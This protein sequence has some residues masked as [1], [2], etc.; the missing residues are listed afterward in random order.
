MYHKGHSGM[1]DFNKL[2][3]HIRQGSDLP[4]NE[5]VMDQLSPKNYHKLKVMI[6]D[7][8][9]PVFVQ[10]T[11]DVMWDI[12]KHSVSKCFEFRQLSS[13]FDQGIE[14]WLEGTS[15]T[16]ADKQKFRDELLKDE[17]LRR[18][19]EFCKCFIKAETYPE[20]KYPRPIKSRTDKFKARMGPIFQGINDCLF[21][22]LKYFIKKIPVRDRPKWLYER[23]CRS[24]KIDC[25]DFSSFEAHFIN[26]MMFAI[27]FP[28]YAWATAKLY[29]HTWFMT[30][31]DILLQPNKCIFYDF[32]V[33]S[34]SRA[35]GEMNTSS[36]NGYSNMIL[37]TYVAR[38]KGAVET[39]QGFEGDDGIVTADPIDSLPLSRDYDDL[40]W[41]CKLVTAE[42]F[43]T[44][45]FCGIVADEV[46]L[47]NVCDIRAYI[48]DFGWTRQQYLW[49]N[50][51][52]HRA[53]IRAKGYSAV[54]QYPGCPII[55]AL[56]HYALRITNDE[57]IHNKMIK[58][59]KKG[60]LADSRY[61]NSKFQEMFDVMLKTYPT[62]IISPPNTR[63]LVERLFG[64]S[65]FKQEQIEDYLDK[66]NVRQPLEIDIEVP[67]VWRYNSDAYIN[68]YPQVS[69]EHQFT[70]LVNY[71]IRVNII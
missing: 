53:L 18:K 46:D 20:F 1:K 14:T 25:T 70:E 27:E 58:M 6:T 42:S 47:I 10:Q 71:L 67:E 28:F 33:F 65:P 8:I 15:Y 2:N 5:F 16:A 34:M 19:D 44:A 22:N 4:L 56:G 59:Y 12:R 17:E 61:K 13:D 9:D 55:D 11:L 29:N 39:E 35:S 26:I 54:Y 31:L 63:L 21:E 43:S 7:V 52:T 68:N 45:S 69:V 24:S 23:F 38:V 3:G 41:S 66:L 49:A 60:Q 57:I 32:I 51:K 50:D 37:F 48:A 30:K 62:R 64:I 40:G 36:G